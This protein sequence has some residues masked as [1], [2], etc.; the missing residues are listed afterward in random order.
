MEWLIIGCV[1]LC[2]IL[3]VAIVALWVR[4]KRHM[5]GYRRIRGASFWLVSS[6]VQEGNQEIDMRDV[7]LGERIGKGMFGEVIY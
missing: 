5:D 4:H 3:I 2:L 7:R 6:Y 1:G